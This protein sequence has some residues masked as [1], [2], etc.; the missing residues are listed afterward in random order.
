MPN[1][2]HKASF[3]FAIAILAISSCKTSRTLTSTRTTPTDTSTLS[4]DSAALIADI[5]LE[6]DSA[7]IPPIITYKDTITVIGVGDIMMATNFPSDDYL[8]PNN[9]SDLWAEVN[10]TLNQADI[11]FGNLE[12]VILND[13]G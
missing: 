6:I 8:S 10:D 1:K 11:T 13:G 7:L 2:N 4:I 3:I 5:P 9:G 12:G